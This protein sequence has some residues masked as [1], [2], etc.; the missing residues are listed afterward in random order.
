[1][2]VKHIHGNITQPKTR[3]GDKM[4]DKITI[5]RYSRDVFAIT[6]DGQTTTWCR[7]D[8]NPSG[9]PFVFS[10]MESLYAAV[11]G[12][13]GCKLQTGVDTDAELMGILWKEDK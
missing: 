1:M 11:K 4:S 10:T 2:I 8:H 13:H 7:Y 3:W 6:I 12:A 5:E 9:L